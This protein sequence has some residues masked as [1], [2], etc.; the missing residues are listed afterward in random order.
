MLGGQNNFDMFQDLKTHGTWFSIS[1][2]VTS[3]FR[4]SSSVN[5]LTSRCCDCMYYEEN[6]DKKRLLRRTLRIRLLNWDSNELEEHR[7]CGRN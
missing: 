6:N 2:N 1:H 3:R 7:S 5:S 4:R